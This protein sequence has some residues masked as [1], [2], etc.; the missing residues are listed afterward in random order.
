MRAFV[1]STLLLCTPTIVMT[2]EKGHVTV[3]GRLPV[4]R[5]WWLRY[6]LRLT[7]PLFHTTHRTSIL[8]ISRITF[9]SIPNPHM[10]YNVEAHDMREISGIPFLSSIG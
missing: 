4:D 9:Q 3:F 2:R 10:P 6:V 5:D 7:P 1:K 8:S